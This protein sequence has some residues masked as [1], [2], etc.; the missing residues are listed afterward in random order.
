MA[1]I[2][3]GCDMKKHDFYDWNKDREV[4]KFETVDD[5]IEDWREYGGKLGDTSVIIY[6]LDR[7]KVDVDFLFECARD[8]A[9]QII[10]AWDEEYGTQDEYTGDDMLDELQKGIEKLIRRTFKGKE[11]WFC[12]VTEQELMGTSP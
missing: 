7:K 2:E 11:P 6:G 3:R 4:F 1:Q 12:E 8:A 5:A 9:E 10:N